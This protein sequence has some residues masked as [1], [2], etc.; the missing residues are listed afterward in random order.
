MANTSGIKA[1]RA[2]VE[3]GVSDTLKRGLTIAQRQLRTFAAGATAIGQGLL[4]AFAIP[5]G[6]FFLSARVFSQF[7]DRMRVVRSVSGA[8]ENQFKSLREEAKRLGAQTSFSARQV[9]DAMAELGRA[10]FTP[11]QIL[12]S[13]EAVLAL[14]RATDTELARA[15]EIAGAALRGF[16][17]DVSEMSRV[18]DVLT[19]TANGS[20]QTLEDLFE[21]LKPVAPI[22]AEAGEGI[23]EISAAI[24]VLA[25][26]GIK[27]S[28]AG[29]SLARAYKNLSNEAKQS[30]L[31]KLGVDALDAQ[32][33]L[34]PIALIINELAKSTANLGSGQRLS[35]FESLFGRG[36]AAA[37][38]LASSGKSFDELVKNIKDSSG[39]ARAAAAEMDAGVGGS[40]R[41]LFS[42]VEAIGI[43]IGE[44][45]SEP[46]KKMTDNAAKVSAIIKAL[47]TQNSSLVATF[48][49]ITAG[50]AAVGLAFIGVGL[51]LSLTATA[52]GG[53]L[54]A[55]AIIPG[56]LT[57]AAAAFTAVVSPIGIATSALA[58]FIAL[59]LTK[60]QLASRALQYLG[61][62]FQR[63]SNYAGEVLNGISDA[64]ANG[65]LELSVKIAG[66]GMEVAWI[67]A[68]SAMKKEWL[69]FQAFT[70]KTGIDLFSAFPEALAGIEN[71]FDNIVADSKSFGRFLNK[72]TIGDSR[73]F[74]EL[75]EIDKADEARVLEKFIDKNAEI[76]KDAQQLN[77]LKDL[78][79]A[80]SKAQSEKLT[81][82][83]DE[84]KDELKTLIEQSKNN[85]ES[86]ANPLFGKVADFTKLLSDQAAELKRVADKTINESTRG[87]FN[88]FAVR[89]L[90]GNGSD[91]SRT[92]AATEKTA[93][94]TNK[95]IRQI[96]NQPG[97]A[98]FA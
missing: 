20:A 5:A 77:I 51:L 95:L 58:A 18:T 68:L 90:S 48:F 88:P 87:T 93:E 34:R 23:E 47:I 42:A 22:A 96:Q 35:I 53:F 36:Q 45:I 11:D 62:T 56:I 78:I 98:R 84:L 92:A 61:A 41:K 25:N 83:V 19:A 21:A 97:S 6:G 9:A 64:I 74:D 94:N 7:D 81:S 3:L 16:N 66:K 91:A 31:K 70:A 67:S 71:I 28:L 73:T 33:N 69:S 55:F 50:A 43:A 46:L 65:N 44:S 72:V 82:K 79:D 17:L 32:G 59:V 52:V 27:G 49:K 86:G 80:G 30:E 76:G 24:A 8:T 54:S 38:K 37:L 60:T 75:K 85:K 39:A 40:L 1:G 2:Y 13:T 12:V 89:G 14:S 10:G 4:K 29:N 57:L 26:N 63:I 15:T